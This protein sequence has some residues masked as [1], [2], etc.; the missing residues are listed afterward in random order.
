MIWESKGR[1]D[2]RLYIYKISEKGGRVEKGRKQDR[3]LGGMKRGE[4]RRGEQG[5]RGK[6]SQHSHRKDSIPWELGKLTPGS[7]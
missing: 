4:K 6:W 1:V 5:Q 2:L 3:T 7:I